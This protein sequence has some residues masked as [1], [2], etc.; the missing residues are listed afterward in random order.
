MFDLILINPELEL[1]NAWIEEFKEFPEVKILTGYFEEV[2]EFDCMV[3][4]A[5]SFGLMDG[6]VDLAIINFF[7]DQLE[8]R[9][10]KFIIEN[11]F[12][13]QPVGTS[14][15][16]E[17]LNEKHPFVAHTPT[18]RIPMDINRTDNIYL[19]MKA[20]LEA[21]WH[22]NLNKENKTIEKVVCPGLGT[23]T[24]RVPAKEAARQMKLAYR[25]FKFPPQ[26]IDWRFAGGRQ[27]E[28]K[29]GTNLGYRKDY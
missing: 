25:N 28:I 29:Y 9:I 26:V 21:V 22:H 6:G 18:M 27:Q 8:K 19:A 23:R 1:C 20:M 16:I 13:E 11:Y 17:T 7:G 4:A 5:N 12:G 3:S 2:Q 15:I 24:G 14:F 10:Q